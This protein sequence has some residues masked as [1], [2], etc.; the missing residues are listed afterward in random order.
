MAYSYDVV[1]VGSGP[2]GLAAAIA[3]Q[4]KGLSVKLLEAKST[5]GGGMR[6]LPLTYPGFVHDV[7]SAVHP[8]A[9][10]SPFFKTLP[11]EQY[12]LEW[13]FPEIALA[14]PFLNGRAAILKTSLDETANSLSGDAAAYRKFF[15][16]LMES[17]DEIGPGLLGPLQ[18]PSAP[19]KLAKFG[20]HA[21]RSATGLANQL[22]EE[23][24]AKGLFAGL[25]AHTIKPLDHSLTSAI[26]LVLA[27]VGHK[28]GWPFPKGGTQTLADALAAYFIAIG[29]TV[30]TNALITSYNQLRFAR[31]KV[32][33]LT[34]KQL[35]RL[36]DLH[37][38]YLYKKQL[39]RYQ[40][41]PGVFKIDYALKEPI[42]FTATECN[43]A[44]TVHLGGTLEEIAHS[45]REVWYGKI[46]EK[47]FVLLSQPTVFDPSRAPEN[48]H[49]CWAYCHVP[50]GSQ[51]DMTALIERQINRF[52]PGFQ[53]LI[54][55]RHV[56]TAVDMEDY[57]ANY[58][59]GDITGGVTN[60][61]QL[62]TRPAIRL[63]P[64]S[65][66]IPDVYICSS[67]TPP[68]AGVHG[69]CGFHAAKKV[70]KDHFLKR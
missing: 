46:P 45:E 67:S 63:S 1:V 59:G 48:K 10:Y 66:P 58:I 56:M 18:F 54:I 41:G 13:V 65:T 23:E 57:N 19:L 55:G 44:G 52:A 12:G 36:K 62:F 6:S 33:D 2:N 5:I 64:Y 38:P 49:T 40:Y 24:Y 9:I 53:D 27:I 37:F 34:P 69:M 35:L 17:W 21:I 26:G 4:Q 60:F 30:E 16:P 70:Y 32:F 51:M 61:A 47:P 39:A 20:I 42:P 50:A 7:C 68:G 3:L 8:L 14:H 15:S 28:V 22:F 31:I 29:G 11:L 25:A 43:R